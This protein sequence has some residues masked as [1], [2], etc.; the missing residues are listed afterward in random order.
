MLE[1]AGVDVLPLIL[2]ALLVCCIIIAILRGPF[3]PKNKIVCSILI[4]LA[5][6][7]TVL[8]IYDCIFGV[9]TEEVNVIQ[10]FTGIQYSTGNRPSK[11]LWLEDYD[12]NGYWGAGFVGRI[13]TREPVR[14]T[15]LGLTRYVYHVYEYDDFYNG[16]REAYDH[17]ISLFLYGG[18]FYIIGAIMFWG[19][20]KKLMIYIR[21]KRWNTFY[22][23]K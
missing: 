6:I 9:V 1:T 14:I 18:L 7:L 10:V 23:K 21:S 5:I 15:Y 12:G 11:N 17:R 4:A 20:I 3:G 16:Y 8:I 19:H 2:L 13:N 22:N